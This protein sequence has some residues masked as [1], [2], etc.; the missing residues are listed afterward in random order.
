M[1]NSIRIGWMYPDTL[2]L[3]GERGNI[4]ALERFT[5]ELGLEPAVHRIDLGTEDFDPLEYDILFFGPGEISSF[6]AV[7]EDIGSYSR[8]LAEYIA[9]GKV[10]LATGATVSM[11]GERITRFDPD[12][13]NGIGEIMEGLCIIP[14]YAEERE[15]VFGDDEW[16]S[17]EFNGRT[18]DLIGNQ[19]HM[20]DIDFNEC[21]GYRAFGKVLY[22]RGNNGNDGIEGIVHNNAIF[23]NMLGPVLI[24]NP[25]LTTE[26]IRTAAAVKG[27]EVTAEDPDFELEVKSNILK[28]K[29]IENKKDQ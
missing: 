15:Y 9:S 16:V 8:S 27:I 24:G 13:E 4:L 2:F 22:G 25:W 20:A 12:A 18:M 23:T 28:Q 19:I 3:H 10:L 11:F 29:F 14:A 1:E 26:I 17:A 6:P 7:M 5:R 21:S